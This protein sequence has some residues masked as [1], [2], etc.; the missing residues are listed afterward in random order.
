MIQEGVF[1][2]G[3]IRRKNKRWFWPKFPVKT[4]LLTC[5]GVKIKV[6]YR[7]VRV[8]RLTT[9]GTRI[10]VKTKSCLKW[11]KDPPRLLGS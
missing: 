10:E 5:I 1:V 7:F 9:V 11:N 6:L 4:C 3:N 8:E 2:T